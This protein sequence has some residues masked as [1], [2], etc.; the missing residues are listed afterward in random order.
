MRRKLA[1]VS[2]LLLACCALPAA[3]Q[4]GRTCT[5]SAT[6]V[7]FGNYTGAV[8]NVTSTITVDCA[9][10]RAYDVALSGGDSGS[11][12][13]RYMVN[14]AAHLNYGLY[15]N[16]TY[17]TNWGNTAATNWVTGTGNGRAQP[18]TVYAQIPAG[19]NVAP[20]TYTDT[21]TVTV[22]GTRI[23]TVTTTFT[24][25]ATIVKNCT[26]SATALSFGA[27]SGA[28]VNAQST[29]SVT[30]TNT[31]TYNVG[32]NAGTATGATVTTRK[33]TGQY[34][35]GTLAYA[36]Y[37]NTGHTQNWGQTVGTD[38]EAGT[39]TGIAQQLIVYGRIAAGTAPAPDGYFDTITATIT[40]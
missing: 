16:S 7:A 33:M 20:G 30:C 35:G 9:N 19:Q 13:A 6:A 24:V 4:T 26:I 2:L 23:N 39:G 31:T 18:L 3:A 11:V 27:Y 25:T 28:L 14:G 38:T 37:R 5:V 36:M 29:I 15:S 22:S 21:I 17:T 34:H 10:G 32:L 12:T 1:L 8:D 40:Y